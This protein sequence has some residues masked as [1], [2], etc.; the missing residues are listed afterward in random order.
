M[1]KIKLSDPINGNLL[2]DH[3]WLEGIT[4]VR[5]YIKE[6]GKKQANVDLKAIYL[7][8]DS[9]SPFRQSNM[10]EEEIKDDVKNHVLKKPRFKWETLD[11]VRDF[12][13]DKMCTPSEGML[14]TFKIQLDRLKYQMD[15][16]GKDDAKYSAKEITTILKNY[17]E[18]M[19]EY[20]ELSGMVAEENALS[21]GSHGGYEESLL[22][23]AGRGG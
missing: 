7:V 18:L 22:E 17:K 6:K 12:W 2:A 16:L 14:R 4:F 21:E 15:T 9:A 23:T 1:S 8:Y 10:E 11:D 3:P 19:T 5:E 20:I 13:L